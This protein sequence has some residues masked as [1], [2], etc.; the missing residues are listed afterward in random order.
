MNSFNITK[1]ENKWIHHN[2]KTSIFKQI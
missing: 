2:I 1:K